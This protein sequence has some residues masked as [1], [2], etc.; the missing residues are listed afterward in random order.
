MRLLAINT[1]FHDTQLDGD[2]GDL[3]ER[4]VGK[5]R[6]VERRLRGILNTTDVISSNFVQNAL[7]RTL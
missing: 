2:A 6:R 3:A 1:V 4:R 7:F 5:A